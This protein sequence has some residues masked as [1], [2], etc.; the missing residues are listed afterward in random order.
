[1]RPEGPEIWL[2]QPFLSITY[3]PNLSHLISSAISHKWGWMLKQGSSCFRLEP[4]FSMCF[5]HDGVGTPCWRSHSSLLQAPPDIWRKHRQLS[6][7]VSRASQKR[8][9]TDS[10][11][12]PRPHS[13]QIKYKPSCHLTHNKCRPSS[14]DLK[15]WS[16]R[17]SFQMDKG[18]SW[19]ELE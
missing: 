11:L 6:S 4:I 7:V 17:E 9:L 5:K 1:M 10:H 2:L 15:G 16:N 12:I 19:K 14:G 3:Y 18:T 13:I 8:G